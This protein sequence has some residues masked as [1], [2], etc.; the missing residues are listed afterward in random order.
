[1]M[2]NSIQRQTAW[3]PPRSVRRLAWLALYALAI[4]INKKYANKIF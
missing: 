3:L 2:T 4:G 1:M